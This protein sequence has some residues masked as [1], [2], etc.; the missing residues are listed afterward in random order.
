MVQVLRD[1]LVRP[2]HVLGK[3]FIDKEAGMTHTAYDSVY[4]VVK[5]NRAH[6]GFGVPS[7]MQCSL[8][9]AVGYV[10]TCTRWMAKA[11]EK[12]EGSGTETWHGGKRCI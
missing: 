8:V 10:R 4:S 2:S 11:I 3:R 5:V 6:G 9:A 7:G 12:R 1:A